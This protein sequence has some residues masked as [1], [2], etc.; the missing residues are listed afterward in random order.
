MN[1]K[2]RKL[3]VGGLALVVA[4][5]VL[6]LKYTGLLDILGDERLATPILL[7]TAGALCAL[8]GFLGCCGAI[9]ENYCLTVSFA[10]L[11]ALVLLVETAAAIA[12]YALHEPLQVSSFISLVLLLYNFSETFCLVGII[13]LKKTYMSDE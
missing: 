2:N 10:V 8:L 5:A 9:R 13:E 1:R 7:L 6:Q 3:Q 4:G 11:L 12:A